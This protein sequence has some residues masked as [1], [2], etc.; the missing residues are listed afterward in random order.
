MNTTLLR[1]LRPATVVRETD[2]F[3]ATRLRDGRVR[4]AC[5]MEGY[6]PQCCRV[7]AKRWEEL[8]TYAD[9]TFDMSCIF[10]LGVGVH[11]V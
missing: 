11:S 10:D 7:S 6:K 1:Q 5:K 8:A 9:N 3:R 2:A 4:I